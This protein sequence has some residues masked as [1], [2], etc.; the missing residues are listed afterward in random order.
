LR[1]FG[2]WVLGIRIAVL[3]ASAVVSFAAF[4][5]AVG[6]RSSVDIRSGPGQ[7]YQVVGKMPA[8]IVINVAKCRTWCAVVWG[9][10]KAYV[11]ANDV[12][13][14]SGQ[15]SVSSPPY[16]PPPQAAAPRVQPP[17]PQAA[18]P[19]VQPP[20]PRPASP[21]WGADRPRVA[22]RQSV[23]PARGY[24]GYVEDGNGDYARR[25]PPVAHP[26]VVDGSVYEEDIPD[27]VYEEAPRG[28]PVYGGYNYQGYGD[29]YGRRGYG[30][31]RGW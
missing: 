5:D 1:E 17:P 2:R 26:P 14:A 18:A 29:G 10:G 25:P 15:P 23:A 22:D 21:E 24:G 16:A 13:A 19:R 6:T 7:E 11:L 8:G 31:R 4:A 30:G 20:P 28:G 12:L 9:D 27:E 3:A